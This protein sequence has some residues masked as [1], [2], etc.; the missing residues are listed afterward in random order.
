MS[1]RKCPASQKC[2]IVKIEKCPMSDFCLKSDSLIS[3]MFCC[4]LIGQKWVLKGDSLNRFMIRSFLPVGLIL[5]FHKCQNKK[6]RALCQAN[7]TSLGLWSLDPLI[8]LPRL[9]PSYFYFTIRHCIRKAF[10]L[11]PFLVSFCPLLVIFS[12]CWLIL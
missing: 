1:G 6:S 12:R 9:L 10:Y 5:N 8:L 7:V 11:L 3:F 2:P 4:P